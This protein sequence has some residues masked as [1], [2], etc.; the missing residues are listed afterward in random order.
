MIE[1]LKIQLRIELTST[2]AIAKMA[3][4][5]LGPLTLLLKQQMQGLQNELHNARQKARQEFGLD[6]YETVNVYNLNRKMIVSAS[7]FER[8][9]DSMEYDFQHIN[10]DKYFKRWLKSQER[11]MAACMLRLCFPAGRLIHL[12]RN[13]HWK[14][15]TGCRHAWRHSAADASEKNFS[16]RFCSSK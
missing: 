2:D 7:V 6:H 1:L 4:E 9:L 10:D 5:K 12:S 3:E 13:N 8:E 16:L 14:G 11:S 15:R